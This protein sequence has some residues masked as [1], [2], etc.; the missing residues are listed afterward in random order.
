MSIKNLHFALIAAL[1][2]VFFFVGTTSAW[3]FTAAKLDMGSVTGG[4]SYLANYFESG[5]GSAQEPYEIAKPEQLYNLAWLQYLGAFNQTSDPDF[6]PFHFYISDKYS[7]TLDMTGYVLPPIG[8]STYPFIGYLDGQGNTVANLTVANVTTQDASEAARIFDL[9]QNVKYLEGTNVSGVE[10]IG[11]MGVVGPLTGSGTYASATNAL[12]DLTIQNITV[13]TETDVAL[14]GLAAGY[15]NGPVSNVAVVGGTV[16]IKSGTTAVDASNYTENLSDYGIVGYATEDYLENVDQD[17]SVS[18]HFVEACKPLFV[19]QQL[20]KELLVAGNDASWGGSI[21]MQS[22]YNNLQD[23]W[24]EAKRNSNYSFSYPARKTITHHVDGTTDE[25][26]GNTTNVT[27]S[28]NASNWNET[29][30]LKALQWDGA[31]QYVFINRTGTS[32][33][34]YLFGRRGYTQTVTEVTEYYG[35][36]ISNNGYYLNASTTAASGSATAQTYWVIDSENHRIYCYANG[37]GTKYYLNYANGN[38]SVSTSPVS[39]WTYAD[40][41]IYYGVGTSGD[42]LY[43]DDGIWKVDALTE[44]TDRYRISFTYNNRTYYLKYNGEEQAVTADNNADNASTWN[45]VSDNVV[46]PNS[47]VRLAYYRTGGIFGIGATTYYAYASAKNGTAYTITNDNKLRYGNNAYL[48]Y[49]NNAWTTT[50]STNNATV[51]TFSQISY[52]LNKDITLGGQTL[53]TYQ[54]QRNETIYPNLPTM[55]PLKYEDP[56]NNTVTDKGNTGY[57]IS[58]G[59][60]SV[61]DIRVSKYAMSSVNVALGQNNYQSARFE[62]ITRTVDGWHRVSDAY[63]GNNSNVSNSI[64]TI[65]KASV[66]DLGLTHYDN[67]RKNLENVFSKDASNIYGL[68][69]INAQISKDNVI[70]VPAGYINGDSFTNMMMP[71]DCIDFHL[72]TP[73]K[74][75]FFA[76]TYYSGNSNFFSLHQIFRD[77]DKNITAI[78]EIKEIYENT[79]DS[80]EIKYVYK[81]VDGTFSPGTPKGSYVFNTTWITNPDNLIDNAVY[82]FEIPANGGEYALGSVYGSDGAYLMYLDIAANGRL[83]S[84][85]A[86]IST[87]HVVDAT[88]SRTYHYQTPSGVD[89]AD[90]NANGNVIQYANANVRLN[91]SGTIQFGRTGNMIQGTTNDATLVQTLTF[92]EEGL[93]YGKGASVRLTEPELKPADYDVNDQIYSKKLIVTLNDATLAI[94]DEITIQYQYD[95]NL[96]D[97]AVRILYTDPLT[98]MILYN[99]DALIDFVDGANTVKIKITTNNGF[100]GEVFTC[101]VRNEG[102]NPP[103]VLPTRVFNSIS[104]NH[105][106]RLSEKESYVEIYPENGENLFKVESDDAAIDI[107]LSSTVD[108]AYMNFDYDVSGVG[109]KSVEVNNDQLIISTD[110]ATAKEISLVLEIPTKENNYGLDANGN[111]RSLSAGLLG[112]STL[113]KG[114]VGKTVLEGKSSAMA[115][116]NVPEED[117]GIVETDEMVVTEGTK[118]N[119]FPESYSIRDESYEI[120]IYGLTLEEAEPEEETDPDVETEPE[121]ET[122]PDVEA[123]SE[124]EINPDVVEKPEE[125]TDP[126]VEAEPEEETDPD[127]EAEPEEE[128]D[129]DVETEPEEETDPDVEAEPG[130]EAKPDVGAEPEEEAK[131]DIAVEPEEEATPGTEEAEAPVAEREDG[132]NLE[133]EI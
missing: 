8:T 72:K 45:R 85:Q 110:T 87:M 36:R 69:F 52:A 34:T 33:Y 70:N 94:N 89:F 5:N 129:P 4:V 73:G 133:T 99:E 123:E 31:G 26:Y 113:S 7:G 9:P 51:F 56:D 59:R 35:Q 55:F 53:L 6:T 71:E 3:Y 65:P 54:I 19:N 95:H 92:L 81:Y 98:Y 116:A 37:D 58:G 20:E 50:N 93:E 109:L 1:F 49:N 41:R 42:Q 126:D 57:V 80:D 27:Y 28:V 86:F 44:A 17:G 117:A 127:V 68:H 62:V 47:N 75:T 18:Y 24:T 48:R 63:N 46:V 105:S 43:C 106:F 122:D 40:G 112:K 2:V 77:E 90:S 104:T 120:L 131:P 23:K 115:S 13:N 111:R 22:M 103:E 101:A 130:E 67:A 82:Y 88:E 84:D 102:E 114:D 118:G 15:V 78:K 124:E 108:D 96:Y 29:V 14:I 38:L 21:D 119:L 91:G 97:D 61:G 11:F 16:K 100:A 66:S 25:S 32:N 83:T 30:Y 12:K 74:I 132:E 121:E 107:A 60:D 125:E 79:E 39:E 64:S 10:I 76:G 128:T